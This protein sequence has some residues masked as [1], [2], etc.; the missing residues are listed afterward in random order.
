MR[1]GHE[2]V[3]RQAMT[4][5]RLIRG[6]IYR[7]H[8]LE[9]T[10]RNNLIYNDHRRGMNQKALAK[11]YGLSVASISR[12]LYVKERQMHPDRIEEE[13]TRERYIR[14]AE[15][16]R[17]HTMLDAIKEMADDQR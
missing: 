2:W 13:E 15:Y 4:D 9:K 3:A 17:L 11:K 14:M 1:Y 10:F 8:I 12:V 7:P 16:A 5:E 6:S